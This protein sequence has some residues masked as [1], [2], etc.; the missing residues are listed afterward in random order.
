[1]DKRCPFCGRRL[2]EYLK[3][4]FLGC[5]ECYNTFREE[6]N[7]DLFNLQGGNLCHTG[8]PPVLSPADKKLVD[9]YKTLFEKREKLGIEGRFAE[10]SAVSIKLRDLEEEMRKRGLKK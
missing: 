3:T 2:S 1:M 7:S 6:I 10:M 9:N 4:G 5:T 8:K